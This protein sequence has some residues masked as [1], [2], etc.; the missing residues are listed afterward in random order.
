MNKSQKP[1]RKKL[2]PVPE[3]DLALAKSA[4]DDASLKQHVDNPAQAPMKDGEP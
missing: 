2:K 1:G 4:G 3:S